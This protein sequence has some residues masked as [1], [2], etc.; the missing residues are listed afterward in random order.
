MSVAVLLALLFRQLVLGKPLLGAKESVDEPII[1]ATVL[2]VTDNW[3]MRSALGKADLA[4]FAAC[5]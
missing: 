5:C 1:G 4:G 2:L 3:T